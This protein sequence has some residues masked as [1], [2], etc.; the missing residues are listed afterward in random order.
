MRKTYSN[1]RAKHRSEM[2]VEP[3]PAMESIDSALNVLSNQ[4]LHFYQLLYKNGLTSPGQHGSPFKLERYFNAGF[5]TPFIKISPSDDKQGS[6]AFL[7][8]D[9]ADEE[10]LKKV[11]LAKEGMGKAKPSLACCS[12]AVVNPCACVAS[13]KCPLHGSMCIG[14]HD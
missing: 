12:L 10:V 3:L 1:Y 13:Y 2:D 9:E 11:A 14:S 4:M 7:V 5:M 8:K 6:L